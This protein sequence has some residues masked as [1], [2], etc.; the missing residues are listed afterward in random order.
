MNEIGPDASYDIHASVH[1]DAAP[2]EV[3]AV[4]SD[5]TR[6]SEWSPET[7]GCAWI[8]GQPGVPG[9]RFRSHHRVGND[10]WT[11]ECEVVIAEPGRRFVWTVLDRSA[12]CRTSIWS[13]EIASDGRRCLLT[14]RYVMRTMPESLRRVMAEL[15]KEKAETFLADRR[16]Q[17]QLALQQT[18]DGIKMTIENR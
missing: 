17:L 12:E 13:F 7:E 5:I 18:V 6:M 15:P 10:T 8:G 11:T 4:A 3:Y 1:V 2:Y 14:Q 9:S 16:T